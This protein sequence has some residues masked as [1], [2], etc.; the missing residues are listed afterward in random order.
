[1]NRYLLTSQV[2]ILTASLL[3]ILR[4]TIDCVQVDIPYVVDGSR[5]LLYE[6]LDAGIYP[7]EIIDDFSMVVEESGTIYVYQD[8]CCDSNLDEIRQRAFRVYP[9]F[10]TTTIKIY[11]ENSCVPYDP[12][13]VPLV[14]IKTLADVVLQTLTPSRQGVGIY[15]VDFEIDPGTYKDVWS[16]QDQPGDPIT[17]IENQFT[18][19]D[20]D[21]STAI[22]FTSPYLNLG[23]V[24]GGIWGGISPEIDLREEI[25]MIL[26]GSP[27]CL[28]HGR[29]WVLRR[30][31]R[32][33]DGNPLHCICYDKE[34][35]DGN[36]NCTYCKGEY[37]K[38]SEELIVGYLAQSTATVGELGILSELN[39]FKSGIFD[40]QKPNF[41]CEHF[42]KPIE[43]DKIY[44]VAIDERNGEIQV[45][46]VRQKKFKV[47]AVYDHMADF[48]RV[49]F[50]KSSLELESK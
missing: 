48:G 31:E 3:K 23:W 16:V 4:L 27:E 17:T 46:V 20:K 45:P 13:S 5:F 18:V 6:I 10:V 42:V 7:Y 35:G 25:K 22:R 14:E 11:F 28:P 47:V 44:Q 1:M 49:E 15:R 38:F 43:G 33:A 2:L 32:D 41:Y 24:S 36:A 40:Y 12:V 19:L 37:F 50:Y 34:T 21:L 29:V 30:L 39:V 26:H 9:G 8:A